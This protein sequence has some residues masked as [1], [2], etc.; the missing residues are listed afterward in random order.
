M[1]AP[2]AIFRGRATV[3]GERL[4]KIEHLVL[5]FGHEV[6][7]NLDRKEGGE[8]AGQEAL[9]AETPHDLADLMPGAVHP[10]AEPVAAGAKPPVDPAL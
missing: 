6:L 2:L 10:L 1:R 5:A 8:T 7:E 3:H 4:A 9:V